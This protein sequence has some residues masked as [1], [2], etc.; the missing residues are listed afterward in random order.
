MAELQKTPLYEKHLALKGAPVEYGGWLMPVQYEGI[1]SEVCATRHSAA[2]FDTSHMGEFLVEGPGAADYLQK[3]LTNDIF[4]LTDGRIIYSPV[5]YPHGGT[6]DDILIYR[7]GQE[8]Y[9]LVVNAANAAKDLAWL[10]EKTKPGVRVSDLSPETALIAIQGPN[11]L[12]ALQA[13]T[14]A[15]LEKLRYYHFIPRVD[16]AGSNCL[17]SRTGY[18][19]E[20]GFEIFCEP[21]AARKLWDALEEVSRSR[22]LGLVPAGLGARDVLRLEA[23]LPL[24]G[25]ELS[26]SISPLEAGL[27]RFVS[28]DKGDFIGREALLRQ[29][30][31]GPARELCGLILLDRGVIREGYRMFN[32]GREIGIVSSGTYSP[33]LKKSIGMAFVT[34]GAVAPGSTIEVMIRERA[35]RAEIVKTPF[36]RRDTK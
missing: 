20:D 15:P 12:E 31:E 30:E 3:V 22:D 17:V 9:L 2:L 34:P 19:G 32:D 36:Y 7:Y 16:L 13:L 29:K 35:H 23:S 5:C 25:H 27:A 18:T 8:K 33:T 10:S 28:F 4:S 1:V 14:Q 24:Y 6:V 21:G 11:S 26:E